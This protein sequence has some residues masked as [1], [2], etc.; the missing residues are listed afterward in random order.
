MLKDC[1]CGSLRSS[2]LP[3]AGN[4]VLLRA[5][6]GSTRRG[7]RE[8]AEDLLC[9]WLWLRCVL[10]KLTRNFSAGQDVRQPEPRQERLQE[11]AEVA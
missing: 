8:Q 9:D 7:V 6:L 3:E 1:V 11:T 10:Q 2:A 4:H 5:L